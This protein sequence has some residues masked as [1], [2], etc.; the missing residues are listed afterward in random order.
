MSSRKWQDSK[1]SRL[2]FGHPCRSPG[3]YNT[4]CQQHTLAK[5]GGSHVFSFG[6]LAGPTLAPDCFTICA[7]PAASR[8]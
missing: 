3:Q 2:T 6:T 7:E 5:I 4:D 8:S 1:D